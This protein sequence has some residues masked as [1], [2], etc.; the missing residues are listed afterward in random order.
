MYSFVMCHQGSLFFFLFEKMHSLKNCLATIILDF[1][2]TAELATQE[3]SNKFS[4]FFF[5][6]L[7]VTMV[8]FSY[9]KGLRGG[10]RQHGGNDLAFLKQT[11]F[12][13]S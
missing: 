3:I 12:R 7:H 6:K 11:A 5:L 2:S 8:L 4:P 9:S 13:K 10:L 1:Y